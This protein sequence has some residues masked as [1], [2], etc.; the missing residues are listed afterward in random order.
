MKVALRKATIVVLANLFNPSIVTRDWLK[1]EGIVKEEPLKCANVPTLALFES[2]S[3]V[4]TVSPDRFEATL[5][6][7][8]P[9]DHLIAG[10]S[11]LASITKTFVEKLHHTPYRSLGINYIWSVKVE[12]DEN[13]SSLLK[14]IF[15]SSKEGFLR[16]FPENDYQVGGIIYFP[17]DVFRVKLIVEPS[18]G[19]V[20]C[21]FNY[22][23]AT[24]DYEKI[25]K[26]IVMAEK[27]W[28]NSRNILNA[29]FE[30]A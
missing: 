9:V 10:I 16:L 11:S 5:K 19:Y 8:E 12:G 21:N 1:R 6:I 23:L 28:D 24:S 30:K 25:I 2:N 4:L 17:Y 13:V 20:T 15:V 18:E 22:S 14:D 3:Y 29:L 7:I 27:N 26:N